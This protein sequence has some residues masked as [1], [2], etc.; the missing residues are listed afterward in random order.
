MKHILFLALFVFLSCKEP[1]VKDMLGDDYRL[2]KY[3]PAWN[4]AKAVEDEDTAEI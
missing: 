4:L 1:N 2:Y 3:T